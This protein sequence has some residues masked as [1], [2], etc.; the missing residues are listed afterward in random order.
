MMIVEGEMP[1]EL[2]M[3]SVQL[4]TSATALY[5]SPASHLAASTE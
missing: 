5:F 2:Q 1:A 3:R 4:Q